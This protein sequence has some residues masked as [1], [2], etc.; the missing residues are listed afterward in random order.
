[1]ACHRLRP[2][3]GSHRHSDGYHRHSHCCCL[4]GHSNRYTHFHPNADSDVYPHRYANLNAYPSH[5]YFN[6]NQHPNSYSNSRPADCNI[7]PHPPNGYTYLYPHPTDS[8][9]APGSAY[10]NL[11]THPT[12]G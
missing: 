7:Y 11:N 10:L 2:F 3:T 1:M 5:R 4:D 12:A 8:H 6:L 9:V